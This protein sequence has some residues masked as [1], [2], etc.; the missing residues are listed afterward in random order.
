MKMMPLRHLLT[1][2]CLVGSLAVLGTRNVSGAVSLSDLISSSGSVVVGGSL[3]FDQFSY[4]GTNESAPADR[5]LIDSVTD[6]LGNYGIRV[7]GGFSDSPGGGDSLALLN[8]RVSTI[9]PMSGISGALLAGNPAAVGIGSYSVSETLS[10]VPTSLSIFDIAPGG[11]THLLDTMTLPS[12]LS[13]INVALSLNGS[14]T[15]GGVTLSFLDQTFTQT[16]NVVPEPSSLVIWLGTLMLVGVV[17]PLTRRQLQ[18][19]SLAK[20]PVSR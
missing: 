14:S 19:R 4:S 12:V 8:Y 20:S 17:V 10:G 13:S 5:V 9:D 3:L 7:H 15:A 6:A 11:P 1:I 18:N 16:D 2:C